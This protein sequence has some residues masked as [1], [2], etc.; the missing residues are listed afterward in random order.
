MARTKQS[1][2]N[3]FF[4]SKN[5]KQHQQDVSSGQQQQQVGDTPSTPIS[6]FTPSPPTIAKIARDFRPPIAQKFPRVD[7]ESKKKRRYRPGTVALREIR[8]FQ[9]TT[10]LLIPKIPFQRLVR[11]ITQNLFPSE[12]YRFQSAAIGAI[13]EAAEAYLVGVME[14]TQL[15]AQHARRMTIM[16]KDMALAIR[17]RTQK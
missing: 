5:G 15:C 8:K 13:Q 4:T 2:P 1:K 16:P 10:D 9:R 6:T 14:D 12:Q 7:K 11:E 3:I 17:L